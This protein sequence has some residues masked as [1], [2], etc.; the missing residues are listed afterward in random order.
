MISATS[1]VARIGPIQRFASPEQLISYA[2]L[3]PACSNRTARGVVGAS[4][5]VARIG[6]CDIM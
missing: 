2:G 6:T 1:I 3:A 5:A 4:A